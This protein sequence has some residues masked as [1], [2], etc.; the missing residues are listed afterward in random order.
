M[1]HRGDSEARA[2]RNI[3]NHPKISSED[4]KEEKLQIA[5]QKFKKSMSEINKIIMKKF[6]T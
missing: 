3:K 2:E 6:S 1:S 4:R 5:T